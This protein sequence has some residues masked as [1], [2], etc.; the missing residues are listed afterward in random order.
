MFSK[1]LK[2]LQFCVVAIC[3]VFSTISAAEDVTGCERFLVPEIAPTSEEQEILK[4]VLQEADLL[5]SLYVSAE[6]A[7]FSL[8]PKGMPHVQLFMGPQFN[9]SVQVITSASLP[10]EELTSLAN[11]AFHRTTESTPHHL[12]LSAI[13]NLDPLGRPRIRTGLA[14]LEGDEKANEDALAKFSVVMLDANEAGKLDNL[15]INLVFYKHLQD[16]LNYTKT[17]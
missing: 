6:P 14:A 17:P 8:Q 15:K 5:K 11:E 2:Y 12:S 10:L 7:V 13:S 16:L 9:A 4:Q 1:R 3:F